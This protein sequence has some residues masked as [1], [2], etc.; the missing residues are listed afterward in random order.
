MVALRANPN[1]AYAE[2]DYYIEGQAT[3][4]DDYNNYSM[5]GM[6]AIRAPQGWDLWT[7]DQEFHDRRA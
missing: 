5:W 3:I 2:P 1:V 7:G 6:D 4:H